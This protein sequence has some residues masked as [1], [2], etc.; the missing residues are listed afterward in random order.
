MEGVLKNNIKLILLGTGVCVPTPKRCQSS[1]F[2]QT[3]ENVFI[4]DMG[5]GA[6]HRM[7]QVGIDIFEIDA[8]FFSHMHVDHNSDFIPFLF[9][10]N[11]HPKRKRKKDLAVIGPYGLKSW[12]NGLSDLYGDYMIPNDFKLIIKEVK[13]SAFFIGEDKIISLSVKHCEN[14]VGYRIET[15][16]KIFAYSGD[17][18]YCEN[19][20]KLGENADIYL[21]ECSYPNARKETHLDLES[22]KEIIYNTNCRKAVLTHIYPQYEDFDFESY[23]SDFEGRFVI[24]NDLMEFLV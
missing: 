18:G 12:I 2:V 16:N 24:A 6:L 13:D 15:N 3:A 23:L 14:A 8:V 1:Y 10:L 7:A 20:V 4:F 17:S 9:S 19:L 22:V 5:E 11:V 21:M